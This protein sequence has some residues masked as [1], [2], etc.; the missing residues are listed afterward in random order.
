MKGSELCQRRMDNIGETMEKLGI[1]KERVCQ[2]Q[3]AIDEYDKVP[4]LIETFMRDT[5]MK[6]GPNPYKGY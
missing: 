2:L 6:L 3:L 5:V 4:D 1:E